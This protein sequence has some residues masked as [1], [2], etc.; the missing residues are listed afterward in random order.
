ME[1]RSGPVRY[2]DTRM[3][4]LLMQ[5]VPTEEQKHGF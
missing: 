1:D 4:P 2:Y 3:F 5:H